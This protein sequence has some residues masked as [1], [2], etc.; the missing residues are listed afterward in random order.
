M[1]ATTD[2][3]RPAPAGSAQEPDALRAL[4]VRAGD[5]WCAL[6]LA[7]VRR[8]IKAL[9]LYPLPGAGAE[10]A[11]LAE[12][13][14]EPL[15]ILSLE[16]LIDA[17]PGAGSDLPI[18]LLV[19]PGGEPIGLLA[20]EAGDIVR[21]DTAAV[22]GAPQGLVRGETRIGERLVQVLDPAGW[23]AEGG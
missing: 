8:V 21:L 15:V 2:A 1:S 10:I 11:G 6:P 7:Q 18:A 20:D 17:P 3:P 22:L 12:V 14:G 19:E 16:R 9:K 5:R 13:D 4:L 23:Q